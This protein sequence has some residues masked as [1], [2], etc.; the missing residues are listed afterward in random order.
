MEERLFKYKKIN[1]RGYIFSTEGMPIILLH[2]YMFTKNVWSQIGLIST[3][4]SENIP[5]WAPDMPYGMKS[6]CLFKT[7]SID[8]NVFY[9]RTIVKD[10][11]KD[12]TPVL[13][14]ASLGGY[15]S[16]RYSVKFNTKGLVLIGPVNVYDKELL[17]SYNMITCPTIIIWG[18]NDRVVN[19]R[20]ME[21]LNR[22]LVNSKLYIY[23]DA[24]HPAYLDYPERFNEDVLKLYKEVTGI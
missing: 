17:K 21:F 11:F 10:W 9:I 13:V 14:G 1:C 20:S 3:L 6:D 8:T 22:M 4:L 18:S 23:E 15:I 16:L 5:F 12:A 7:R 19:Q 24:G 2:G